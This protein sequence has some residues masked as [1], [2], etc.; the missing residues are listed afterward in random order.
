MKGGNMRRFKFTVIMLLALIVLASCAGS[1]Y[2]VMYGVSDWYYV[3]HI[4]L[5]AKYPAETPETQAW[6]R[7]NIHPYMNI[8]KRLVI[9]MGAIE[10]NDS[11]KT[12]LMASEILAIATGI[13]YDAS[14]M[15]AA[16]KT[17]DYDTMEAEAFALKS[18][19]IK[20]LEERR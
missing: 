14:R 10:K 17:K 9:A 15:V 12:T 4:T 18:F 13:K 3:N 7:K 16:I 6:L 8:M 2:K 20:K 11:V 1:K 19:I 5:E